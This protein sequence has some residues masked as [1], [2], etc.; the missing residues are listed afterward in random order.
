MPSNFILNIFFI[1]PNK[2]VNGGIISIFSLCKES[3]TISPQNI[4]SVLCVY[5]G[6]VSYKENDLFANNEYIYSFSELL[7]KNSTISSFIFHIPEYAVE[8]IVNGLQQ[9]N[10][11]GK[12]IRLNVLNQNIKFMP[13]IGTFSNLLTIASSITQTTAHER[14]S[15]QE[16]ASTYATPL[17]H[18]S[19]YLDK[20]QYNPSMYSE[21]K[22]TILYSPD[23]HIKKDEIIK[24]LKTSFPD[25][26]IIEINKLTYEEYKKAIR[27]AKYVITF[28]EGLDGYL[29]ESCFSGTVTFSVFNNDFFPNTD[30]LDLPGIYTTYADM[31][32]RIVSDIKRME[33]DKNIYTEFNQQMLK[34]IE[35]IYD[36]RI[37]RSNL[38][39]FYKNDFDFYP[40]QDDLSI[41]VKKALIE[42]NKIIYDWQGT[43]KKKDGHIAEIEQSNKDY[44]DLLSKSDKELVEMK[45]SISWRITS[46]LRS[47]RKKIR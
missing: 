2:I 5:P 15:T 20:S 26:K 30:F 46:P 11:A 43:N 7:E 17:L 36:S 1:P 14:Y 10:L 35:V 25:F 47:I 12:T 33:N 6:E 28:G 32:N 8:S 44:A 23:G 45:D 21:K 18:L 24:L 9:F 34:K 3:R 40:K 19:V 42:K 16:I 38:K 37:Y 4:E 29:I 31:Y 39:R 41:F 22:D 13:S 27:T